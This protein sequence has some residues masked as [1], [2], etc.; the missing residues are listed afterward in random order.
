MM[1][2]REYSYDDVCYL[3]NHVE[4]YGTGCKNTTMIITKIIK[5]ELHQN[6]ETAMYVTQEPH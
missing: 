5:S 3:N 2:S 1:K 4:W 6:I